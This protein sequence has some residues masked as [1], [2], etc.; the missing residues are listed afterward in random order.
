MA[1][2]TA[3]HALAISDR[4]YVLELGRHIFEGTKAEMLASVAV[5]WSLL[6]TNEQ[7]AGFGDV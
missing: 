4:G 5:R 1:E 3:R 2:Q 6:G 7:R